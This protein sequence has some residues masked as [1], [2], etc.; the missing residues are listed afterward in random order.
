MT[1]R[2][3][4]PRAKIGNVPVD[5]IAMDA[6]IE[7]LLQ[8]IEEK[9]GGYVVTPNVDHIVQAERDHHLPIIYQE[10]VLSL[11]DGAP[12]AWAMSRITKQTITKVSG[13][14]LIAPLCRRASEH[15]RSFYLL[16]GMPGVAT[17]AAFRLQEM[18]PSL[19]IVGTD[20]PPVGFENDPQLLSV[21][22][23]RIRTAKP[24]FVLV[25]L[26]CPKQEYFMHNY[27][28]VLAPALLVGIGGSL[29]FL[30]GKFRRAPAW[31]SQAGLEWIYRLMQEPRRLAE[32][33]LRRDPA[34]LPILWRTFLEHRTKVASSTSIALQR[35]S[36]A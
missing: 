26:G 27:H 21:T 36:T 28:T 13:A 11:P 1:Q 22:L 31:M 7:F 24:H 5:G 2:A 33:Y 3:E 6:A 10:S 35:S 16:G 8:K 9:S 15:G 32:R 25:A 19:A 34:F 12:I 18:F 20:S 17:Q 29:D 30:A 14:D 23:R 4:W